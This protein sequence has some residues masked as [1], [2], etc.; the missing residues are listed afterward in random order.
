MNTSQHTVDDINGIS[1]PP[2][3]NNRPGFNPNVANAKPRK[4]FRPKTQNRPATKVTSDKIKWIDP[5]PIPSGINV[6]N[7]SETPLE[8]AVADFDI[9]PNFLDPTVD[10]V[11]S[12]I[13]ALAH[14]S[15]V[16]ADQIVPYTEMIRATAELKLVKKLYSTAKP[17]E[18]SN[19]LKLKGIFYDTSKIPTPIIQAAQIAGHF[20]SKLGRMEVRHLEQLALTAAANASQRIT[21]AHNPRLHGQLTPIPGDTSIMIWNTSGSIDYL[22]SKVQEEIDIR[23]S[24]HRFE[25]QI[26]EH[27]ISIS[28]PSRN[29]LNLADYFAS[30]NVTNDPNSYVRNR[31]QV[32]QTRRYT[33]LTNA[34]NVLLTEVGM[35]ASPISVIEVGNNGTHIFAEYARTCEYRMEAYYQLDDVSTLD[36][37]TSAQLSSQLGPMDTKSPFPLS[38]ADQALGY[39]L[40][41]CTNF[42]YYGNWREGSTVR[43]TNMLNEFVNVTSKR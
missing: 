33:D 9:S 43:R 14:R 22:H 12:V 28:T 19:L 26:G 36:E 13:E 41:P 29:D 24:T 8:E 39:I 16:E 2:I 21:E 30:L 37:G 7:F 31:I 4:G 23:C 27:N 6:T 40:A 42:R 35:I 5:L 17:S 38:G 25:I 15:T 20:D 1:T 10:V 18:K 11:I 3:G 34:N 32:L